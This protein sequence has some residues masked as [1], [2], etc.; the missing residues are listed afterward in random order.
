MDSTKNNPARLRT[1]AAFLMTPVIVLLSAYLYGQ[2]AQIIRFYADQGFSLDGHNPHIGSEIGITWVT[3]AYRRFLPGEATFQLLKW[4]DKPDLYP[5][6]TYF[7]G[8]SV[9]ILASVLILY[10]LTTLFYPLE[11][12]V[13]G[14]SIPWF[15]PMF[16]AH[17]QNL[18]RRDGLLFL[19]GALG[20]YL[21]HNQKR[22]ETF[23][24]AKYATAGGIAAVG[25]LSHE[26]FAFNYFPLFLILALITELSPRETIPPALAA[27]TSFRKK[28]TSSTKALSLISAIP[29][30]AALAMAYLRIK[31]EPSAILYSQQAF[32]SDNSFIDKNTHLSGSIL[33]M[34]DYSKE[35][36]PLN[37][38]ASQIAATIIIFLGSTMV[39]VLLSLLFKEDAPCPRADEK[40]FPNMR[41]TSFYYSRSFL[42]RN[43][44]LLEILALSACSIPLYIMALDYGRWASQFLLAATLLIAA[45]KKRGRISI[46][47]SCLLGKRPAAGVLAIVIA[48]S[49]FTDAHLCCAST[50]ALFTPTMSKFSIG[51]NQIGRLFSAFHR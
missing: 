25:I 2:T 22:S 50:K 6:A 18:A 10:I 23:S 7:A 20:A 12:I 34:A 29:F 9:S 49:M 8:I 48:A 35:F 30:G 46:L 44:L 41:I 31:S 15:T 36:F 24:Y 40:L 19:L 47:K 27:R 45:E 43:R 28:L 37:Q 38:T 14:L 17:V 26:S 11:A 4:I 42:Y 33:A 13:I 3:G 39:A 32:L 5:F 16:S 51:K 1:V 21:I